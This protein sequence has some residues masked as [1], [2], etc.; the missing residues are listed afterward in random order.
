MRSL[1]SLRSVTPP[2]LARAAAVSAICFA[3]CWKLVARLLYVSSR[4][5]VSVCV[6]VCVCVCLCVCVCV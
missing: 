3:W 5:G 2:D 1:A 4:L 6:C